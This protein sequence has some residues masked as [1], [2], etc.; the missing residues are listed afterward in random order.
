MKH[1]LTPQL[2][3]MFYCFFSPRLN[4][5]QTFGFNTARTTQL[6]TDTLIVSDKVHTYERFRKVRDTVTKQSTGAFRALVVV[7]TTVYGADK[8]DSTTGIILTAG[9]IESLYSLASLL[10]SGPG[11]ARINCGWLLHEEVSEQL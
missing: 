5:R 6:V 8:D 4:E 10:K 1:V 7:S 9:S 11:D 2:G 3:R